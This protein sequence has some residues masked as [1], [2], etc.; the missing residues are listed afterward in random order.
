MPP[1]NTPPVRTTIDPDAWEPL[2]EDGV[3]MGEVH[4]FLQDERA[5][6]PLLGGLWRIGPDEGTALPYKV[7]G[8]EV[9][10]VLEGRLRIDTAGGDQL[11]L[12]P[13]DV[14]SLP[15]GHEATWRFLELTKLLFVYG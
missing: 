9:V 8:M 11:E 7:A 14:L 1:A 10:H 6:R 2:I 15:D 4:M 3:R 12:Q 5:E 13:G